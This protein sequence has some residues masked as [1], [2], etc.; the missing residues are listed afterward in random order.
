MYVVTVI[1][2][3]EYFSL[4]KSDRDRQLICG[5]YMNAKIVV[6]IDLYLHCIPKMALQPS[7]GKFVTSL[8][9]QNGSNCFTELSPSFCCFVGGDVG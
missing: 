1:D 5:G 7:Q 8:C 9:N 2:L 4:I 6:C 3:Q